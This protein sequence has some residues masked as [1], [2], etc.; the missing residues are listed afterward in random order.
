[1]AGGKF[2][3]GTGTA[4]DP[5]LIEDAHDFNAIRL[6]SNGYYFQLIKDINMNVPP[7]NMGAGWQPIPFFNSQIDGQGHKVSGLRIWSKGEDVGIALMST[8]MDKFKIINTHFDDIYFEMITEDKGGKIFTLFGATVEHSSNISVTAYQGCS[9]SGKLKLEAPNANFN[10]SGLVTKKTQRNSNIGGSQA[11]TAQYIYDC[12]IDFENL[13]STNI[14]LFGYLQS[15][16]NNGYP[17]QVSPVRNIIKLKGNFISHTRNS[18]WSHNRIAPRDS[19]FVEEFGRDYS[20]LEDSGIPVK[21][22]EFLSAPE[23]LPGYVSASHLGRQTWYFPG[24]TY[25]RMVD[26]SRN[27]FLIEADGKIYTYDS[28][29]GGLVQVGGAP[30]LIDMFTLYGMDYIESVPVSAWNQLRQD[31]GL[32]EIHCYV[33]KIPGKS[34][35]T[36]R[37]AL[38]FAQALDNKVVM[39]ATIDFAQ[40]NN[41]I[42][43]IRIPAINQQEEPEPVDPPDIEAPI[44]ALNGDNPM[45]VNV[46][47]EYIDP[48]ATAIDNTDG[49]LTEQIEISGQ[50]DTST[51]GEY[52]IT[53]KV[54]D[55]FGNEASATRTIIVEEVKEEPISEPRDQD[56]ENN[57][58]ATEPE[59]N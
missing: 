36:N 34:L 14:S 35:V 42:H 29:L 26:Y 21:N 51:P 52:T 38:S 4:L 56:E 7:Y 59:A 16:S 5:F 30:I 58:E 1:M 54:S 23:N 3:G 18:T 41:D 48:G 44:I 45:T 31:H 15:Y 57:S 39:R 24:E 47:E 20:K 37:E 28:K 8:P 9:F 43:R 11:P 25:P 49:D 27:K 46:G 17:A 40:H 50:V 2:A 33:E 10:N 22:V 53:Y 19:Y 13:G 12:L 6:Y 55:S 32:I